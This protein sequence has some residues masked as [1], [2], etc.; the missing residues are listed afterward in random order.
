[1]D[2]HYIEGGATAHAVAGAHT[3]DFAGQDRYRVWFL[4][5]QGRMPR[6]CNHP[7]DGL[8]WAG[9]GQPQVALFGVG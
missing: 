3:A 6:T 5:Q 1:M 8:S 9:F 2:R 4:D 7:L